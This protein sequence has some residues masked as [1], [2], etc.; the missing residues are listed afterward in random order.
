MLGR[1]YVERSKTVK[2]NEDG[3]MEFSFL[4]EI[5]TPVYDVVAAV[6]CSYYLEMDGMCLLVSQILGLVTDK[7]TT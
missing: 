2:P 6:K 4:E 3:S 1:T 7:N 5:I